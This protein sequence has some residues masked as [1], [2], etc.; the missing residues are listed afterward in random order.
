MR[1]VMKTPTAQRD[2][3]RRAPVDL[4]A[5]R[6]ARAAGLGYVLDTA[7]GLTRKRAGKSF[8]YV[9]ARGRRVSDARTL[10]RI[11]ALAIPPAWTAVWICT[12]ANGHIQATG[13]DARGRKQYRYHPRWREARDESKY[14]QLL[15]FGRSLPALRARV[16][17]DL[18]QPE[19]DRTKVLAAITRL[20]ELTLIRVGNEEYARDNDS[21]GLTTLLDRHVDVSASSMRFSFRG[22]SGRDREVVLRDRRLARVVKRCQDVPGKILF[23]YPSEDGP[24]RRVTS[25]DVNAYLREVSGLDVTAKTFRTW[26]GTMAVMCALAQQPVP[27][28]E[29]AERRAIVG[30]VKRASEILGN[31]PTVCRK[32]YCHPAV[33]ADFADGTLAGRSGVCGELQAEGTRL[34]AREKVLL[35][36][37]TRHERKSKAR[38][39]KSG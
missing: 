37:L 6:M 28:S 19:L 39:R 18:A 17:E 14:H 12:H 38:P 9:D 2:A 10:E 8:T 29:T 20:L 1:E 31:T 32:Y 30:A 26:G 33:L 11:R 23:Q 25:A 13:R 3:A 21:Y 4:A 36:V 7:A 27:S 5:V 24:P 35:E 15:A 22:K 34:S 16:I